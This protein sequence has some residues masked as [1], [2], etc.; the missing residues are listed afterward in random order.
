MRMRLSLCLIA[1]VACGCGSAFEV[2]ARP[3]AFQ[4]LDLGV[5]FDGA[6]RDL[7]CFNTACGGCSSWAKWDQTPVAVGDPCL[8][9]GTWQCNGTDLVCSSSACLSCPQPVSGTVCGAD[10]HSI[11]ELVTVAGACTAWDFGSGI[12][13]CNHDANDKC[14]QACSNSGGKYT[15]E[16]HC[17][18]DDGFGPAD[19]YSPTETCQSLAN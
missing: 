4:T 9:T 5:L 2:P 10:G 12:S 18:A 11:I 19:D 7:T 8:I 13:S 14:Q 15:C 17:L 3:D 1:L 6:P 16:A